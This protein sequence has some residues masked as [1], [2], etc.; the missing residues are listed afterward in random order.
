M[1]WSPKGEVQGGGKGGTPKGGCFTC[2]GAH[3]ARDC[4]KGKG[5]GKGVNGVDEDGAINDGIGFSG[6]ELGGGIGADQAQV[7]WDYQQAL[8][9]EDWAASYSIDYE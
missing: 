3:W 7:E 6:L 5:K 9:G 1:S 2:G 4:P 8:Y